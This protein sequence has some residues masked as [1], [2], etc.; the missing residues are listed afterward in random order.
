M[1]RMFGVWQMVAKLVHPSLVVGSG[2]VAVLGGGWA[3]LMKV[4][5]NR[6]SCWLGDAG[7]SV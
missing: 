3:F 4:G 1:G 2:R 7:K 5:S 6:W